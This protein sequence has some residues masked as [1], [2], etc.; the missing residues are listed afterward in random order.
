MSKRRQ[1]VE[2]PTRPEGYREAAHK[3]KRSHCKRA[4]CKR[5]LTALAAAALALFVTSA[6]PARQGGAT[7]YV[8]DD[9]GRLHAVIP[10]AGEAVVYE[11]DAAG[12]IKA[13]RRLAATALVLFD[14][15]PRAG[16]SGDLVTLFGVGFGAGV[17]GVS[18]NGVPARVLGAT[19]SALTA[20][21]PQGATTGPISVETAGALAV[22]PRPFTV[23]GMRLSPTAPRVFFGES[24]QFNASVY[25]DGDP[26]LTWSVDDAAGGNGPTG[27]VSPGGLYTAPGTAGNF[28]VRATL[29]SDTDFYAET[30][31]AVRDPADTG[32][33]RAPALSVRRGL[34]SGARLVGNTVSVRHGYADGVGVALSALTSVSYG[35]PE[36]QA[37]TSSVSAM[38]GPYIESVAPAAVGRGSTVTLTL[39][40]ANL[41]GVSAIQFINPSGAPA[42]GLSVLNLG[43]NPEGTVLTATLAVSGAATAG[44]YVLLVITHAGDSGGNTIQI[45]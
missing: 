16:I 20:E 31:V 22:T 35:D 37:G 44:Q 32:E 30:Q 36:G 38:K 14:F 26:A 7:R 6:A 42:T 5:A 13:V 10:P 40:G 41:A 29:A 27:T 8:Y 4:L 9:N 39:T 1:K 43:T 23:R 18:F 33:P 11:Y 17:T 45:N 34:S 24:V 2:V 12:N 28:V 15:S 19:Q 25:T 21:V 3:L